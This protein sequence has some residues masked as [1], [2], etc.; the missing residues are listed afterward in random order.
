MKTR[1]GGKQPTC[2]DNAAPPP[3]AP[4]SMIPARVRPGSHA[5]DTIGYGG[6]GGAVYTGPDAHTIFNKRALFRSNRAGAAGGAL[7][8]MGVTTIRSGA[9]FSR[10]RAQVR[11]IR[12]A[13]A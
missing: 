3:I 12:T 7:H 5:A 11:A 8:T 1:G 13:Y 10:N 4:G 9:T 2:R 6:E